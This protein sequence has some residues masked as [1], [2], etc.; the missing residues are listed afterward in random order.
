MSQFYLTLPIITTVSTVLCPIGMY[1]TERLGAKLTCLIGG[2]ITI[3][4]TYL[5]GVSSSPF[6]YILLFSIGFGF[7]K[8]F[9]YPMALEAGWTHLPG[10]KGFVSGFVTSGMGLGPFV[11]GIVANKLVNP[12][13]LQP[14]PVVV[15]GAIEYYFPKS[16]NDRVPFMM[17]CM[18]GLFII[19]IA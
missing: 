9:L 10:R 15:N 5:A 8:S 14:T 3:S 19:I 13:N 7:G 4:T 1:T 11:M 6:G 16:V 17:N 18:V 12:L 2:I